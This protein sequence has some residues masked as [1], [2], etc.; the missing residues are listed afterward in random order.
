MPF[1]ASHSTFN[2]FCNKLVESVGRVV[3]AVWLS[4][5]RRGNPGDWRQSSGEHDYGADS[6][7]IVVADDDRFY[8]ALFSALE[9]SHVILQEHFFFFFFFFLQRV[10]EYPPK[11]CTSVVGGHIDR[12][13]SII[14]VDGGR[15]LLNTETPPWLVFG[16]WAISV[17][18]QILKIN[19]YLKQEW[20]L[21]F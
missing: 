6:V 9:R 13:G 7:P 5:Q 10:F 17:L 2:S 19:K 11:W 15:T 20:R 1:W 18:K 14:F 16:D 12:V 8:V 4:I 21:A 3:C